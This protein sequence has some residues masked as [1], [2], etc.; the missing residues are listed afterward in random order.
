MSDDDGQK[1][2]IDWLRTMAG[3]L[4]AVSSAV[5]LS[6][7]GAAGTLIGAA[8]GS[9]IA[10]V[11]GAVYAQGLATSKEQL[12][13]AQ[14]AARTKVGLAQAEVLRANRRQGDD[15]AVRA[16]L[17]QAEEQLD[18]ARTDLETLE[19][20]P[21]EKPGWRERLAVLPWKRIAVVAGGIFATAV[22]AITAFEVATGSSV[23]EITGGSDKGDGTTIGR[24]GGGDDA[25]QDE[26]P[27]EQKDEPGDDPSEEPSS[28]PTPEDEPSDEP[29]D[30]PSEEPSLDPTPS[31]SL[32][33][34]SSEPSESS[35]PE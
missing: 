17:S 34:P 26:S 5:L 31:P 4:A 6:T 14:A 12:A 19:D 22:I 3:A 1:L 15:T 33:T 25:K 35:A 11:G 29:S 13:R 9:V 10:T 21:Q 23:S 32:P 20:E 27:E 18:E 16:H 2:E 30:A 8:L 24:I 28:G 7:L